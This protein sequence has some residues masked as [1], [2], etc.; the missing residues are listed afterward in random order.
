MIVGPDGNRLTG[1]AEAAGGTNTIAGVA[2]AAQSTSQGI[3]ETRQATTELA[4][5]PAEL[6]QLVST[7]RI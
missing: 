6:N 1:V 5:M 4:R 2:E 7:S 3:V